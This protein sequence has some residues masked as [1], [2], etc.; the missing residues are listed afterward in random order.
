M[1]TS[2]ACGLL[3]ISMSVSAEAGEAVIKEGGTAT[4]TPPS[5]MPIPVEESLLASRTYKL[6]L[7]CGGLN[8]DLKRVDEVIKKRK[9]PQLMPAEAD[10][11][12]RA[13][14]SV[15][16][17]EPS[18]GMEDRQLVLERSHIERLRAEFRCGY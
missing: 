4:I 9:L 8:D 12:A 2:F 17:D 1:K 6:V 13:P 18:A 16:R 10:Q 3:L 7:N 5:Q 15:D 14:A 11:A